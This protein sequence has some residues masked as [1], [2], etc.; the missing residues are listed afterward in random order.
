MAAKSQDKTKTLLGILNGTVELSQLLLPR[1]YT[2][3]LI[4]GVCTINGEDM[5]EV[6]MSEADFREWQKRLREIDHLVLFKHQDGNAPLIDIDNS[7]PNKVVWN[8]QKSYPEANNNANDNASELQANAEA[9]KPPAKGKAKRKRKPEESPVMPQQ[10]EDKKPEQINGGKLSEYG[11][12][13]G[14]G[15]E[16]NRQFFAL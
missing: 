6:V 5:K 15:S 4:N 11:I 8:E 13:W 2:A 12:T 9:I 3:Y 16:A 10:I 14:P 1:R 7:D